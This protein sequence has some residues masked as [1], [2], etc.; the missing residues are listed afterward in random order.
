MKHTILLCTCDKQRAA[1]LETGHTFSDLMVENVLNAPQTIYFFSL[2]G[3]PPILLRVFVPSCL[4]ITP[5]KTVQSLSRLV[6][7]LNCLAA[8]SFSRTEELQIYDFSRLCWQ[9]RFKPPFLQVV[10]KLKHLRA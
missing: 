3:T 8:C 9:N 2:T 6:L 7:V 10:L 5:T 1:S 4:S